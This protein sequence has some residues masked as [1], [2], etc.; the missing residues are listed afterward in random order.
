MYIFPG[1]GLAASV[2]GITKITDQMLYEAAV[3]CVSCISADE[4]SQGRTFPHVRN[5]RKVSH[6]VACAGIII[7]LLYAN[8]YYNNSN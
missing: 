8:I 4:V 3:A 6:T 1:I 5:I 2:A 7:S